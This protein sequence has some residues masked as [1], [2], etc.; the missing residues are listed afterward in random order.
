MILCRRNWGIDVH[1]Q[2]VS[3]SILQGKATARHVR[4]LLACWSMVAK[5]RRAMAGA[6]TMQLAIQYIQKPF[7][8]WREAA[9]WWSRARSLTTSALALYTSHSQSQV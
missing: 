8:A 7:A 2:R 1:N 5:Q 3:I 9:A 4:S 6:I